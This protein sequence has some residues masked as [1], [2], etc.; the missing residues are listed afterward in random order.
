MYMVIAH[1]IW[2][3][4][5]PPKKYQTTIGQ[6]QYK[7]PQFEIMVWD[8]KS[9]LPLL[10]TV[11]LFERSIAKC[12]Y[13]IQKIDV[14]KFIILYHY[15]GIYLDLDI[16][17]EQPFSVDFL[18][19]LFREDLV[20]SKIQF[21]SFIPIQLVNNG[22]I[23]AKKGSPIILQ[24]LAEIEWNQPF[25][26]NKDW[27]VLDTVGPL[28]ISKWCQK[29]NNVKLIDQKYVEG[30][31]LINFGDKSRRGIF[32]THKHDNNWMDAYFYLL[33]L[34]ANY[35]LYLAAIIFIIYFVVYK[36]K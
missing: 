28:F 1:F 31:P 35:G 32:I 4:G 34:S 30:R 19:D 10:K 29:N 7:N 23:F 25:F 24:L 3:Q 6:F 12:D 26:K 11:P 18:N 14:Y 2:F 5:P 33:V 8:E 21:I 15:G 22:I 20:F 27:I 36:L 17:V 13:M 9:L 16:D